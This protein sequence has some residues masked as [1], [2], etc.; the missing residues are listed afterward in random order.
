MADVD[1]LLN[2]ELAAY[3]ANSNEPHII[4]GE[5]R[6]ITIPD[7]LKRIAVKG[8][9]NIETVTFDCPRYWDEHDMSKMYV[10]VVY[11]RSDGES[12]RYLADNVRVDETDENIMH[13]DWTIKIEATCVAGDLKIQV[14]IKTTDSEGYDDNHWSSEINNKAY[15]SDSLD[16][17]N[18]LNENIKPDIINQIITRLDNEHVSYDEDTGELT[19]SS[20][21]LSYDDKTGEL[22][23]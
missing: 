18:E 11:E 5:N 6:F 19:V 13:F 9:H 23:I 12:G 17:G 8:D 4:V 7:E 10:Y 1:E 15:I 14:C 2:K 3:T 16:C 22:I 20:Y 21:Q